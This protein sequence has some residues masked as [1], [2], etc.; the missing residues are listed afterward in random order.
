MRLEGR[1]AIV[2]GAA[3]GIGKGI[4]LRFAREGAKVVVDDVNTEGGQQVVDSIRADGGSAEFV[5]A[6]ISVAADRDRMFAAAQEAFGGLDVLVNNAICAVHHIT[7]NDLD[8][9]VD[10][11]LKGTYE[12]CMAALEPMK[13]RGGGSIVNISS[14]NGLIGL[15]GIHAYSAA[16]GAIISLTR[17][18]AVEQGPAGIRVNTICPGT[19]Q[20]EVWG[21]IL[22]EKPSIW[23][24]LVRFYPIGR[25]GTV[26]DIANCAL[27][28]ASDESSF[29]TGATFTIDGGL[30]A[31][32]KNFDI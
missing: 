23:Q 20:T 6:D 8:P 9:V 17:S 4:A 18:L 16:K 29:A 12:C 26:E 14:V 21:P 24:D 31:G 19:I 25:L 2:T 22:A 27:F 1:V 13:A 32:Y 11:L 5:Q 10:V 7:D 28:L 15:Q 30:T 3:R